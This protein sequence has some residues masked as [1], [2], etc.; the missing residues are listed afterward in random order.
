MLTT[1]DVVHVSVHGYHLQAQILL[2][3]LEMAE[4]RNFM[5][6]ELIQAIP[7]VGIHPWLVV[8][9]ACNSGVPRSATHADEALSFPT[10]LLEAGANTAIGAS[11][12]ADEGATALLADRFYAELAD[13]CSP[14]VALNRAQRW[15]RSATAGELRELTR[16]LRK[17]D[18]GPKEAAKTLQLRFGETAPTER[19]YLHPFYW[20]ALTVHGRTAA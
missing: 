4:D 3:F 7:I 9:S 8:L 15:I 17:A 1:Q 11:W 18:D 14:A 5:L 13:G 12:M 2:S 16:G 10:A 19:P 20:A 6:Y